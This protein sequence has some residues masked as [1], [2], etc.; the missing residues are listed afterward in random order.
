MKAITNIFQHVESVLKKY[1]ASIFNIN[2]KYKWILYEF[3]FKINLLYLVKY[4]KYIYHYVFFILHI[5]VCVCIGYRKGFFG[6]IF[7]TFVL[8]IKKVL[9][10]FFL[11]LK[12]ICR[13]LN[14]FDKNCQGIYWIII[15]IKTL[16]VFCPNLIFDFLFK[17]TGEFN[18]IFRDNNKVIKEFLRTYLIKLKMNSDEI[19]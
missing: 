6:G 5:Y 19:F 8:C 18:W 1:L 17:R 14:A 10:Y 4:N 9:K 3:S 11:L 7:S 13:C 15:M 12:C 2:E 16:L